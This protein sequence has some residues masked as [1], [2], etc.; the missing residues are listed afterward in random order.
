MND[1]WNRSLSIIKKE[2]NE[3]T[4]NAWFAPLKPLSLDSDKFTLGGPNKFF[5]DWVRSKHVP[6]IKQAVTEITGQDLFIDFE[7]VKV[8]KTEPAKKVPSSSSTDRIAAG[9]PMVKQTPEQKTQQKKEDNKS[10]GWLQSVF[11]SSNKAASYEEIVRK[12]GLNPNYTFD[13]FVVGSSNRFAQAAALAVCD[14]LAKVYNPFFIYGAVG[15]GKTH[16]MQAIGH[17]VLKKNPRLSVSYLSSEEFT[18]QLITAI[19][20]KTTSSFRNK[21]RNV[22]ILLIDDIQFI[23]GKEST[24]EEFFHTFNSLHDAHKQIVICSDRSP[25][26]IQ[27]LEERLVSRFEWGLKADIQLPDF[28]TRKAIIEKKSE[29]EEVSVPPEVLTFLAENIKTNIREMEGALIR[30]VAYSKLTGEK[31]SLR[32]AKKVLHGMISEEEKNITIHLIQRVVSEYFGIAEEGMKSRK[33]TRSISYP[34]QIAMLL[35][36]ELT[37]YS[38]PD[39]GGFFGG[40]DHTTVLHAC[41]KISKEREEKESTKKTLE[42]LV[43]LIKA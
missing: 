6:L 18:N 36:R 5:L 26:E 29:N 19:R 39:I 32:L 21:Y 2:V 10:S 30:V 41:D 11:G 8:E 15:L 23:A 7:I 34:R 1:V 25:K 33:R 43:Q 42:K 37:D 24:Q 28:E 22:D 3:Q 38:F 13:N 4:F 12:V 16:L 14:R 20:K 40:R 35:S 31:M 27:D 17:A 9:G